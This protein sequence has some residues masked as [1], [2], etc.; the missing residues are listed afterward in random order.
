MHRSPPNRN[1]HSRIAIHPSKVI[2]EL[3]ADR[4]ETQARLE[5]LERVIPVAEALFAVLTKDQKAEADM[6]FGGL[7]RRHEAALDTRG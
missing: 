7:L 1:L 2:D 3:Y 6:L 4:R 5:R